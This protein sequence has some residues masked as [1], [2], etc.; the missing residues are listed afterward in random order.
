[1]SAGPDSSYIDLRARA[2]EQVNCGRL[3]SR[4]VESVSA[5]Y[6]SSGKLC[7]LCDQ[8][9]TATQVEYEVS[10]YAKETFTLHVSCY[11]AWRDECLERTLER[12]QASQPANPPVVAAAGA[13]EST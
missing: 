9:I 5:G 7:S 12:G 2:R 11:T 3:P 10:G 13:P 4:L 1:M 6:G 8:P